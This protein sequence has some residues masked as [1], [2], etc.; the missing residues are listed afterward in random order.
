MCGI[1]GYVGTE[2]IERERIDA[3]LHL[4]RRRGP[5]A[6]ASWH[7]APRPGRHVY[8]LHG[9]LSIIDLHDRS[10][11]PFQFGDQTLAFNG[12]IYNYLE[13]KP[14]LVS[15]GHAFETTSD[16]EVLIKL[17]AEFGAPALERCEGM[18]AFASYDRAADTLLLSRDRFGEKPLY[19]YRDQTGL[20]F[21]S[22]IKFIF[23]LLGRRLPVDYT[24]LYR[25]LVNGYKA[26][27]KA[28]G[29]FYEGI[30]ELPPATVLSV[31]GD[32]DEREARYWTPSFAEDETLGYADAVGGVR[33]RLER[34]VA[35]RLRAD[36]PLAFCMSGGIDSNALIAIA[37]R[38][39][40]YDVHG[41]TVLNVD[42]RYEE[43]D[44]VEQSVRELGLRH[45][46]VPIT[47]DGFLDNLRTLVAQ[48]DAPIYTI[49]YYVQ[50]LL[51]ASVAEAGYRISISGTAADELLTGYY[52][53]HNL[54]LHAIRDEPGFGPALA[55]WQA[56]VAPI[57]RNPFL[58][59]A[60]LYLENPG[61][62]DHVF[63]NSRGFSEYL[64][65]GWWEPFAE[66]QYCSSMLRNRML[67]ELFHEAVPVILHEDDLNAMYFS[68]ENRSPY[69]DRELA[70]FCFRIPSRHLVR[71]GYA[72]VV[73]RDA[74]SG[75]VGDHV[76]W[77]RRKV[78][79]NAPV[80]SFLNLDDRR[81]REWLL[82]GGPIYDHVHA[83]KV[84]ALARKESL[85][86]SE[87]K[88]LFNVVCAKAFLEQEAMPH[89]AAPH[90]AVA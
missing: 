88:F 30:R 44:A 6:R 31:S 70:E 34:S 5:D 2:V 90:E 54:F 89:E 80:T 26:L 73:L 32:G 61:C 45:T 81:L 7:H 24:H 59:N 47:P 56:H 25:Y 20:Y 18:W 79:F 19:T 28:P 1:A 17:L 37:K 71:D 16:T 50:W 3:A 75:I 69:L 29:A 58:Q 84:E 9:R 8:L 11:Q 86:N 82:D 46:W 53:H 40:N 4:M 15:R 67:N 22:E 21:G 12:E 43:R 63:L 49:S 74:M 78:G 14:E 13:L 42:A 85:L 68:I 83:P 62:R 55:A 39:L 35:L 52:D 36:V 65:D 33:D 77:N 51:M 87:S 76:L 10:N 38:R 23:G 57:V 27:Y 64:V 72:K 48:H 66:T 41:F 60:R